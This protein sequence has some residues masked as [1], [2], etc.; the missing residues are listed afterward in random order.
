MK[1]L[2]TIAATAAALTSFSAAAMAEN[3]NHPAAYGP[4]IEMMINGHTMHIQAI[5]DSNGGEWIIMSREEVGDMLGHKMDQLHYTD[6]Q[7]R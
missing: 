5:K 4:V 3:V 6:V 7:A 1:M 2:L